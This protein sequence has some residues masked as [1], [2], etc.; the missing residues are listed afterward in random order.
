MSQSELV[1]AMKL[2][3]FLTLRTLRNK[4]RLRRFESASQN[5]VSYIAPKLLGE[6]GGVRQEL[7]QTETYTEFRAAVT[8]LSTHS[9]IHLFQ[10]AYTG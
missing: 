10:N 8:S 4:R 7:V 2:R 5:N 3:L 1:L 9:S 6:T